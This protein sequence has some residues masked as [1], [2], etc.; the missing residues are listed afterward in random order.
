MRTVLIPHPADRRLVLLA[1]R[2]FVAAHGGPYKAQNPEEAMSATANS[3]AA[4][5][6]RRLIGRIEE[7]HGLDPP[8]ELPPCPRSGEP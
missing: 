2:E 7:V 3:L 6:V 4:Q 1:L 5:E 8:C